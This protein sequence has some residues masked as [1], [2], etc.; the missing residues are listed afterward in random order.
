MIIKLEE[1]HM[2][3]LLT[4]QRPQADILAFAQAS[5][6]TVIVKEPFTLSK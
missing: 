5:E 3:L 2:Q 4:L 1:T 6:Y